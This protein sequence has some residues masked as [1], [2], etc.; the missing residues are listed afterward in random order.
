MCRS[1]GKLEKAASTMRSTVHVISVEPSTQRIRLCPWLSVAAARAASTGARRPR[2]ARHPPR[3]CP[4]LR[5]LRCAACPAELGR[6]G[7]LCQPAARRAAAG[8]RQLSPCAGSRRGAGFVASLQHLCP[9]L[10]CDWLGS[11][12]AP[13]GDLPGPLLVTKSSPPATEVAIEHVW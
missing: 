11:R 3:S 10:C 12:T 2:A 9:P 4:L 1:A 6:C 13:A 5:G 7:P 8:A